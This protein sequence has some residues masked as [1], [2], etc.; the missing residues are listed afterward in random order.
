MIY[1]YRA[2]IVQPAVRLDVSCVVTKRIFSFDTYIAIAGLY[3]P[4]GFNGKVTKPIECTADRLVLSYTRQRKVDRYLRHCVDTSVLRCI[5][6]ITS[7]NYFFVHSL[8]TLWQNYIQDALVTPRLREAK[9]AAK[10]A[11]ARAVAPSPA[12]PVQSET[13]EETSTA[14]EPTATSN[15]STA[16]PPGSGDSG[17]EAGSRTSVGRKDVSSEAA[18]NGVAPAAEEDEEDDGDAEV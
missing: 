1:L 13:C 3:P 10:A 15:R 7:H 14:P 8:S 4:S 12:K 16:P 18:K 11:A 5:S 2:Q 9:K 17:G 6:F